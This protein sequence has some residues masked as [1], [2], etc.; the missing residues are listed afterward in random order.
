MI[1]GLLCDFNREFG[2]P[3][4]AP[5]RLTARLGELLEAGETVVLVAGEP[6]A[7]VAL[8]RFRAAL[9]S[10]GEECYLAELYVVPAR[11]G[12]G[13]GRALMEGVIALARERGA[14]TIEI[15][16]DEPDLV[17]RRL[18]ESLGFSN[19]VRGAD[20]PVM[21]VYELELDATT[22]EATRRP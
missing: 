21:Y 20:G 14:D 6:P 19:R 12:A 17:A 18:Y 1:A 3:T 8:V 15:G 4:P 11:R 9:W 22:E 10:S 7:G 13:L 5:E 16:V 2:E